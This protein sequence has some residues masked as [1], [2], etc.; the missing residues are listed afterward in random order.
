MAAVS[1]GALDPQ[2]GWFA[3]LTIIAALI[4]LIAVAGGLAAWGTSDAFAN[5]L[6]ATTE[7]IVLAT[8]TATDNA[9]HA[10]SS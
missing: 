5:P 10:S 8:D 4:V 9:L 1:T 3:Q 7:L 2:H 6:D